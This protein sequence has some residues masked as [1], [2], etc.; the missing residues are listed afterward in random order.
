MKMLYHLY[1]KSRLR[2]SVKVTCKTH[3]LMLQV[4]FLAAQQQTP[5]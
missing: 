1:M 3:D 4:R 5:A 2:G